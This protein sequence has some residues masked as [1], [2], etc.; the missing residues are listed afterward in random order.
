MSFFRKESKAVE[1]DKAYLGLRDLAFEQNGDSNG[2]D[3]LGDSDPYKGIVEFQ[4]S[5]TPITVFAAL[6][7]TA[8]IYFSSGGGFI[9]GG[10][11]SRNISDLAKYLVSGMKEY[12]SEL[13][14]SKVLGLPKDE[15]EVVYYAVTREGIYSYKGSVKQA[16]EKKCKMYKLFYISQYI[17]SEYRKIHED[18]E[19]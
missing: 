13:S 11:K 15:D 2:W 10:Q 9:G 5:G 1:Y 6:D 8:S 14:I 16:G 12:Q 18:K 3:K 4:V 7:G 17:I 19:K